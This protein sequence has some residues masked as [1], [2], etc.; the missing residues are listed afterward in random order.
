MAPTTEAS[1]S[2]EPT[3]RSMPRVRMTSSWPIASTAIAAVWASTLLALP[4]V[5]NTGESER[6]GDDETDQHQDRTEADD[7]RGRRAAAGS[8]AAGGRQSCPCDVSGGDG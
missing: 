2:V 1:A 4:V 5:R 6:H 3:E 8:G 7:C